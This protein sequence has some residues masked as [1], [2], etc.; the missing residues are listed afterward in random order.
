MRAIDD[1]S[2]VANAT[3][4]MTPMIDASPEVEHGDVVRA[5]DG[6]VAAGIASVRFRGTRPPRNR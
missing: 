6:F 5:L 2:K 3:F 4:N 1:P